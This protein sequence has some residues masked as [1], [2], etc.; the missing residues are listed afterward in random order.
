ITITNGGKV[1]IQNSNPLYQLTVN[2]DMLVSS[3]AHFFGSL[4]Q[5]SGQ[6]VETSQIK[7][8]DANGLHLT[9]QNGN[10]I[11]VGDGGNVGIGTTPDIAY[12][13]DV[14]GPVNFTGPIFQNSELFDPS[15]W[16]VDGNILRYDYGTSPGGVV[17]GDI[18][19][20]MSGYRLRVNEKT[21][22]QYL[23]T[24]A[25]RVNGDLMAEWHQTGSGAVYNNGPYTKVSIGTSNLNYMLT[26]AGTIH[27]REVLV[28]TSA[29]AD[30]VFDE[31]YSLSKLSELETFVKNNKRLPNI[32]SEIQMIED[33][34][35]LGEMQIKM[36]QK[37][38]ELTLYII[39]QDKRILE[40]EKQQKRK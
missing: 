27:A 38:E 24:T 22:C 7:A 15:P 16:T 9:D 13:L 18:Q 31:N 3:D 19:S 21:Y 35:N 26:V 8:P 34:L 11:F 2:G 12:M 4:L 25:L 28:T 5:L 14:N 37:I 10:G 20:P 33:G 30:F 39:E 23:Y 6:F 1:G 36:L 17:I 32:P 29:G 40:L